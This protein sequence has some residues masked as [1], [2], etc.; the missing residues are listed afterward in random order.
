MGFDFNF[1]ENVLCYFKNMIFR[2]SSSGLGRGIFSCH[3]TWAFWLVLQNRKAHVL[4]RWRLSTTYTEN[5]ELAF[6]CD[7]LLEWAHIHSDL[8]LHSCLK[9]IRYIQ[10]KNETNILLLKYLTLVPNCVYTYAWIVTT[11]SLNLELH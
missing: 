10:E 9:P 2:V 6:L 5:F 1:L 4:N 7:L 11:V 8:Y 3:V